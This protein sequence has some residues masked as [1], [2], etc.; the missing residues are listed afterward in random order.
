MLSSTIRAYAVKI[1]IIY[2]MFSVSL[3]TEMWKLFTLQRTT[4]AAETMTR[5]IITDKK[6]E[7]DSTLNKLNM[8]KS[9]LQAQTYIPCT[10][11][12]PSTSLLVLL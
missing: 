4:A 7:A 8:L 2:I 12:F 5:K 11:L 3:D 10:L 9:C 6:L 1:Y